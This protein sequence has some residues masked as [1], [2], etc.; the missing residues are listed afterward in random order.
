MNVPFR[1]IRERF[2]NFQE[3]FPEDGD[4]VM[5]PA[6]RVYRDIGYDGMIMPDHVPRIP[7]DEAR[8]RAF[9]FAFGYILALLQ[10]VYSQRSS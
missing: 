2:L 1:N 10:L 8:R 6:V 9:A 5:I 4:V 7:A 3:A